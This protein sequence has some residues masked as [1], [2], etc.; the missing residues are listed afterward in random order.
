M[1]KRAGRKP[2]RGDAPRRAGGR[3]T[4]P[5]APPVYQRSAIWRDVCGPRRRTTSNRPAPSTDATTT[6]AANR[7]TAAP[8]DA[9]GLTRYPF[10]S[11]LSCTGVS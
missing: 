6:A 5:G 3:K 1:G 11:S 8:V 9:S 4:R 10:Q 7:P 2:H